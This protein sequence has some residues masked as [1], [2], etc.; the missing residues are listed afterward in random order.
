MCDYYIQMY[1][2]S[3]FYLIT[4]RKIK[5]LS[6]INLGLFDLINLDYLMFLLRNDNF[7][8]LYIST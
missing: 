1:Y 5:K 8:Q 6:Q 4:Y 7:K 3:N 2:Y